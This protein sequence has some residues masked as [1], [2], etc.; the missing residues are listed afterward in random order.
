MIERVQGFYGFTRT[1]FGRNLAPSMLHR[2]GAHAEAAARIVWCIN[3][4]ALGV[5]TGEVGAGKTFALRAAVASLDPARHTVIYLPNPAVGM[6]GLYD[7]IVTSLGGT[8]RFHSASLTAQ[9]TE[10]LAAEVD[11]RGRTPVI[12]I[13]ES[14]L[15]GHHEL[16][17]IRM[18]TNC[19]MDSNTPFAVLLIGQPTLR[20]K[21][22]LGVLAALDQRIGLRYQMPAMTKQETDSYIKHH[23]TIAGRSD[24]L[25]SDDAV[26]L[27]HATS[28]GLP[29][30]FNNLA[31]QSL[32]AA[33]TEEKSMVDESSTR[34]GIAESVATD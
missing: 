25:F 6:R 34:A 26:D 15:L 24:P 14:H 8:P 1:L 3:N 17:A 13:D 2:H 22:K 10:A 33:F 28:R 18:L 32:V 16:D 11:E 29:R 27:I 12:V 19:E 7:L 20:K 23:L 4:R 9:A 30:S 31:W 5:I 21:M